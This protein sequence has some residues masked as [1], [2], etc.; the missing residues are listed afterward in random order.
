MEFGDVME[1]DWKVKI[2]VSACQECET[3]KKRERS[4]IIPIVD[5][6]PNP[7]ALMMVESQNDPLIVMITETKIPNHSYLVFKCQDIICLL[8]HS[9]RAIAEYWLA[10]HRRKVV[11]L[12]QQTI[13]AQKKR[14]KKKNRK[15]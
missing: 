5:D 6:T 1:E 14:G 12:Q 15:K 11:N 7:V 9:R 4:R 3:C 13:R 2:R 10:D 8:T